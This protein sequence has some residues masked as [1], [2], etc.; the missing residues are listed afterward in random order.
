MAIDRLVPFDR[1]PPQSLEMEQAVL[2]AMLIEREAQRWV[3]RT[4]LV[5]SAYG[6]HPPAR[7]LLIRYEDL[8]ADAPR[9]LRSIYSWLGLAPPEDL[10]ARVDARSFDALPTSAKGSG[11]FHRAATPGMWRDN[12]SAE[13]QQVCQKVM[14]PTLAAMGYGPDGIPARS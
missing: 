8:L 9:Q 3:A 11:K 7:R 13:E 14:G 2:G 10:L 4:E 12:L 6:R 5:R 1:I